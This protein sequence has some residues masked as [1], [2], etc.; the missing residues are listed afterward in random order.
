MK[1]RMLGDANDE[2]G[3]NYGRG[4][5][6][7]VTDKIRKLLDTSCEE[8]KITS[9]ETSQPVKYK[10]AEPAQNKMET[11][12]PAP[13]PAPAAAPKPGRNNRNK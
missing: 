11:A 3:N 8:I 1:I 12:A 9:Q 5:I 4:R 2:Y 10:T 6:Y 7:E 13:A